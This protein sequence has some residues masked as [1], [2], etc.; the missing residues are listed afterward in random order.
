MLLDHRT[1]LGVA[2]IEAY[3]PGVAPAVVA[4]DLAVHNALVS[5]VKNYGPR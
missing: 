5:K 1:R 4:G 3:A 2:G